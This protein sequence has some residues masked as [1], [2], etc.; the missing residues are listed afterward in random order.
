MVSYLRANPGCSKSTGT[1]NLLLLQLQHCIFERAWGGEGLG[2]YFLNPFLQPV[3][4]LR[5]LCSL[6]LQGVRIPTL[7]SFDV[8]PIKAG[9]EALVM[10]RPVFRLARNLVRAHNLTDNTEYLPGK[11]I[12]A[13]VAARTAQMVNLT[14]V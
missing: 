1:L 12:N 14:Q 13:T 2:S 9:D 3:L 10:P 5:L 8:V 11:C 7:G 4:N 6:P